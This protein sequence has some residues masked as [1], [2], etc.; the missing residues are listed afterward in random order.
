MFAIQVCSL[1][2]VC[3][4]QFFNK[5]IVGSLALSFIF[6][7][8][9]AIYGSVSIS[10]HHLEFSASCIQCFCPFGI[11]RSKCRQCLLCC[12][13]HMLFTDVTTCGSHSITNIAYTLTI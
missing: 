10:V 13:F 8:S 3:I 2:M 6:A 11:V 7:A 9:V 1:A 12:D 4:L 5:M